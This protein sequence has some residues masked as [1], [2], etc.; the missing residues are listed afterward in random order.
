MSSLP[1]PH[2]SLFSP[3]SSTSFRPPGHPSAA[4]PTRQPT[5]SSL[6][7]ALGTERP[8]LPSYSQQPPP[9]SSSSLPMSSDGRYMYQHQQGMTSYDY[10][11]YPHNSYDASQFPQSHP[12]QPR[13]SQPHPPSEHVP[14]NP[15]QPH[16][17]PPYGSAPYTVPHSAPPQ[18]NGEAWTQFSH[19][20]AAPPSVPETP[21]P[22]PLSRPEPATALA[23]PPAPPSQRGYAAS[24][25]PQPNTEMRRAAGTPKAADPPSQ[26]KRKPR[27]KEVTAPRHSSPLTSTPLDIDFGKLIESYRI[28]IDT[29]TALS[30]DP[31]AVQGRPPS[32]EALQRIT[33]SAAVGLRLL[34]STVGP[35]P[36]GTVPSA[37]A[38]IVTPGNTEEGDAAAKRQ[39]EAPVP[40]GQTCLGC[41]A[42]STPEWRRGP[43]G[44]RTLC[45]ACGLV[46]AKLIKKR[47]RDAARRAANTQDAN[48]GAPTDEAGYASSGDEDESASQ[49]F[50]MEDEHGSRD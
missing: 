6:G 41:N 34:G 19:P 50:R 31:G 35:E 21:V 17:H 8:G 33:Q 3:A 42:T 2:R 7:E 39:T 48:D 11:S 25:Q 38:P 5:Y 44:P 26:P 24:P 47:K 10:A 30:N 1:F 16:Y 28:I 27:E 43:L 18:W 14:Y 15:P 4:P 37:E 29:T 32:L 13:S 40:E 36:P 9:P 49:E 12:R 23:P 45:N 20:V 22:P 46:Y